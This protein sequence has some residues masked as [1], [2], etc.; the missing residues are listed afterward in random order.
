MLEESTPSKYDSSVSRTVPTMPSRISLA[1]SAAGVQVIGSP[2]FTSAPS[3]STPLDAPMEYDTLCVSP[4]PAVP[5]VISDGVP[6]VNSPPG[7]DSVAS[8]YSMTR[9]GELLPVPP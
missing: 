8:S 3:F 2:A 9:R 4:L 1:S 5:T 6:M 7:T